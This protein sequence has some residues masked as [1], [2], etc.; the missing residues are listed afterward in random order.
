R[1]KQRNRLRR[2]RCRRRR[3]QQQQQQLAQ[4]HQQYLQWERSFISNPINSVVTDHH[5]KDSVQPITIEFDLTTMI[6]LMTITSS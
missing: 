1:H 2:R 5:N 4:Q 3:L 6:G